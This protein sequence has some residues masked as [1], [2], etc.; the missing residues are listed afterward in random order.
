MKAHS[1]CILLALAPW[2]LSCAT[3]G[4][5][6]PD[7]AGSSPVPPPEISIP[8][9]LEPP[10]PAFAQLCQLGTSCLELDPRPFEPCLLSTRH[11]SDKAVEPMQA[12][13]RPTELPA[14][15]EIAA[16]R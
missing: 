4:D 8:L 13:D 16:H 15:P 14:R 2:M 5:S 3:R 9:P 11:C 7:S 12:R 6:A 1:T 10:E